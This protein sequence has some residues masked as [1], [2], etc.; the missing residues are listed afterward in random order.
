VVVRTVTVDLWGTLFLDT[1]GSDNRYKGRR[2]A[3]FDAILRG[4]GRAFPMAK[5][6]RA[7]EDSAGFLRRVWTANRD[8]SVNEHVRAIVRGLDRALGDT[9]DGHLLEALVQAYA[10]PALL[11]PP[12]FDDTAREAFTQLRARGITLALVS[13]TMRTPGTVLRKL[14]TGAGLLQL[15]AHLMFSDELGVRKPATEIFL[16]TLRRVGG[17]PATAVHVGDDAVLDVEGAQNAGMRAVQVVGRAGAT[18]ATRADRTIT[19]LGELPAAI[20]SLEAA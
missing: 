4:E 1:P 7:Y 9:L 15:F 20:A 14:L 12:T 6:E 10:R 16:A 13:N 19:C 11:V 2:L 18:G 5:L 8:V 17:E 3:D